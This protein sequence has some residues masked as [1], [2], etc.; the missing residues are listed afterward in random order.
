MTALITRHKVQVQNRKTRRDAAGGRVT[1]N[2][3]DLITVRCLYEPVRE[4]SSAEEVEAG[5]FQIVHLLVIRA[6][7]WPGDVKSHVIVEGQMYET[8]GAPQKVDMSRKL[9]HWRITV[10]W[11]GEAP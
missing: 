2:V 11:I 1:E 6:K 9:R 5:G 8:L 10:R 7:K 4:W 3:G